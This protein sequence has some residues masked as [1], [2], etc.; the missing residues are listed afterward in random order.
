MSW[1]DRSTSFSIN[2]LCRKSNR[3]PPNSKDP[4]VYATLFSRGSLLFLLFFHMNQEGTCIRDTF[5]SLNSFFAFSES[6]CFKLVLPSYQ[7]VLLFHF[8][9]NREAS[10]FPPHTSTFATISLGSR[11]LIASC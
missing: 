11:V 3:L 10:S 9:T 1:S 6:F 4:T 8:H 2:Q 7:S 5:F